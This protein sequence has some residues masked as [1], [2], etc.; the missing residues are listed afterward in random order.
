MRIEKVGDLISID[1]NGYNTNLSKRDC[2]KFITTFENN[3]IKKFPALVIEVGKPTAIIANGNQ[4][5][6]EKVE[7]GTTYQWTFPEQENIILITKLKKACKFPIENP[8]PAVT[9]E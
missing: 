4:I 5:I 9:S 2:I 1:N 6:L 8:K 3:L 7:N